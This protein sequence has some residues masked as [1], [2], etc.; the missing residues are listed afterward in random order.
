M[1]GLWRTAIQF[2]KVV[3]NNLFMVKDGSETPRQV[4]MKS[5]ADYTMAKKFGHLVPKLLSYHMAHIALYYQQFLSR[6][7][8]IYANEPKTTVA[9]LF[10][11]AP[12]ARRG[13]R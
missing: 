1:R 5:D 2:L 9:T 3:F 8:R 6:F 12:S 7:S 13:I 4:D 11:Q 10:A